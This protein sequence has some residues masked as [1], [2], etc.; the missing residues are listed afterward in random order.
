[1]RGTRAIPLTSQQ[2][3]KIWG[4]ARNVEDNGGLTAK[5]MPDGYKARPE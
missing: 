5:L 4:E 1:M 2:R 3:I